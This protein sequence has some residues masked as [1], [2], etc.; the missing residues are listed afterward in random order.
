MA[1][2][3]SVRTN[4][5][6]VPREVR[7]PGAIVRIG[8]ALLLVAAVGFIYYEAAG[9][10]F[11]NDDFQWLQGTRELELANL[12][13]FDR[14]DHFY[15][16]VIEIYFHVGQ[17]LFGCNAL[18]FHLASIGVHL[19]NTLLLFLFARA[20]SG[21]LPFA[22]LTALFFCVQP[23]YVQAVVWVGAIT[24]LL[25][26]LWYLLTL[27]LHLL[28][29]QRR[30]SVFYALALVAFAACLLTHESSATLLPMMLA[31]EA[32]LLLQ[33][34]SPFKEM[35]NPARAARYVPFGL[36]LAGY[37][38]IAY[39]V[40]TRSYLV[41]EGHYRFGWHAVPNMFRYL[42]ALSVWKRAWTSY[43]V[44]A[45]VLGALVIRGGPR[46]RFA[47]LWIFVTLAPASFFTW[48]IE[49]RYLYLP[50]AG[51]AMVLADVSLGLHALLSRSF[52]GRVAR[53]AAAI[54][55]AALSVRFAVFAQKS[56]R[57]FRAATQPYE[58]LAVTVRQ[59][60]PAPSP[61]AVVIIDQ[62]QAKGVP[63]LYL[64]P[65]VQT[66]YCRGDIRVVI[67]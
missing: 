33:A 6:P 44:I 28:F 14:Y 1:A 3:A 30:R 57:D 66:I 38:A 7:R 5:L 35:L 65:A 54:V 26:A 19:L 62:E 55:V 34:G 13:R 63:A 31:L 48:G 25:P 53:V 64:E 29:V 27:W 50:A 17:R 49:S 41:R 22:A 67:R 11:F 4:H 10:Y 45:A 46:L 43:A 21:H 24:D 42:V 32:M 2:E 40:N 61:G 51:F 8:G 23:G 16:P 60:N 56:A 18:P 39:V 52:S 12:L 59:S 36:L 20:L 9:T 15:R 58:S 37:L 47:V